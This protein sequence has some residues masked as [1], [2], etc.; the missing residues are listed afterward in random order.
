MPPKNPQPHQSRTEGTFSVFRSAST[1]TD[2]L[3]TL[4]LEGDIANAYKKAAELKELLS[5]QDMKER[6]SKANRLPCD[7]VLQCFLK[8]A[9]AAQVP[10]KKLNHYAHIFLDVVAMLRNGYTYEQA[11]AHGMSGLKKSA[12]LDWKRKIGEAIEFYWCRITNPEVRFEEMIAG[13]ENVTCLADASFLKTDRKGARVRSKNGKN[14]VNANY[15]GKRRTACWSFEC[16]VTCQGRP[17]AVKAC[18]EGRHHDMNY[19]RIR[20]GRFPRFPVPHRKWEIVCFDSGYI[21]CFTHPCNPL[22]KKK[23]QKKAEHQQRHNEAANRQND[24]DEWEDEEDEEEEEEQQQQQQQQNQQQIDDW[25]E[26]TDMQ[27]Q[28]I[29]NLIAQSGKEVR[30]CDGYNFENMMNGETVILLGDGKDVKK[31]P[32]GAAKDL[33]NANGFIGVGQGHPGLFTII[34]GPTIVTTNSL[35][36]TQIDGSNFQRFSSAK[37]SADPNLRVIKNNN[38]INHQQRDLHI[39]IP[40]PKVLLAHRTINNDD[41]RIGDYLVRG[42]QY[43][44]LI[45][46]L[47]EFRCNRITIHLESA[48][49]NN[50]PL[51][52]LGTVNEEAQ[53]AVGFREPKALFINK[54][55][56]LAGYLIR[57]PDNTRTFISRKNMHAEFSR[58][59]IDNFKDFIKSEYTDKGRIVKRWTRRKFWNLHHARVRSRVERFYGWMTAWKCFK[60]SGFRNDRTAGAAINIVVFLEHWLFDL[61]DAYTAEQD[62]PVLRPRPWN[63]N[64]SKNILKFRLL[65]AAPG[66][67][68]EQLENDENKQHEIWDQILRSQ[69]NCQED[70][71]EMVAVQRYAEFQKE[72]ILN[73]LIKMQCYPMVKNHRGLIGDARKNAG[74]QYAKDDSDES[75]WTDDDSAYPNDDERVKFSLRD[76]EIGEEL[77]GEEEEEEEEEQQQQQQQQDIAVNQPQNQQQNQPDGNE[78]EEQQDDGNLNDDDDDDEQDNDPFFNQQMPQATIRNP[79][80]QHFQQQQMMMMMNNEEDS[81]GEF[82]NKNIPLI[83]RGCQLS[84]VEIIRIW[85]HEKGDELTDRERAAV[86]VAQGAGAPL[87]MM[88]AKEAG[89]NRALLIGKE[90]SPEEMWA[91]WVADAWTDFK[92]QLAFLNYGS[93]LLF[94]EF[95]ART[96]EAFIEKRQDAIKNYNLEQICDLFEKVSANRKLTSFPPTRRPRE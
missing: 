43:T 66:T 20:G 33:Q 89:R 86:G 92:F 68:Q 94:K 95:G 81:G 50:N 17:I 46:S 87:S 19:H 14:F 83:S 90:K 71:S 54:P 15:S 58:G 27:K 96:I 24:D 48:H 70:M 53:A 77:V 10:E 34:N 22:K 4:L 76:R 65:H 39:I 5:V 62:D 11:A 30:V 8:L 36:R 78:D 9:D 3:C 25:I 67:S 40:R 16:W 47:L 91:E 69:C 31:G 88:F 41:V 51:V 57:E 79:T 93:E 56:R 44:S 82:N 2:S 55:N 80:E 29:L 18:I 74:R 7:A 45:R 72:I 85:T 13:F 1:I 60:H 38:N 37:F 49:F 64:I 6:W 26:L 32:F 21:G 63:Y 12:L 73:T 61:R 42:E 28:N 59:N 75:Y 84:L 52:F 23:K 35:E